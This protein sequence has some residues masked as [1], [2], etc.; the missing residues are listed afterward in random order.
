MRN[1]DRP[2]LNLRERMKNVKIILIKY[3][4][5]LCLR[6]NINAG[7]RCEKLQI[8]YFIIVYA[9]YNGINWVCFILVFFVKCK[10]NEIKYNA[11]LC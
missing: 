4:C 6:N 10:T 7:R 5:A 1:G 9:Y 2:K 3:K 8:N 11:R